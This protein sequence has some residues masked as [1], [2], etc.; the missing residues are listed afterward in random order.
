MALI[1]TIAVDGGQ[2][3]IWQFSETADELFVQIQLT[4]LE[5]AELSKYSYEKRKTEWLA[6]RVMLRQLIGSDFLIKYSEFGKPI[7]T[8]SKY[9]YLSITHAREY[10]AVFVHES[11]EVGIDLECIS[12]NYNPI[13]KR[14]LS[15]EEQKKVNGNPL[16]QC[17]YWCAK[18]AVFKVVPHD[19]VEFKEEILIQAFDL[20][21]E[22]S[23]S[24]NFVHKD[25]QRDFQLSYI[26]L[27]NYGLVWVV[28]RH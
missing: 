12:R 17:L 4:G 3:G 26:L 21:S 13:E 22:G 25:D 11:H 5:K 6:V 16:L 24:A 19:G 8:H 14:Y 28:D 15:T 20:E 1:Q 10:A 9:K 18:E 23:F 27:E 2:I 7:L